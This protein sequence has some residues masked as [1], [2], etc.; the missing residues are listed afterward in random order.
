MDIPR[1]A[2]HAQMTREV[3]ARIICKVAGDECLQQNLPQFEC[4]GKSNSFNRIARVEL[5]MSEYMLF[6]Y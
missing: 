6:T 4:L 5:H 2:R 1:S 3:A